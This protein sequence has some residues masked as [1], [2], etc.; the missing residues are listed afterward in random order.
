MTPDCDLCKEILHTLK[1]CYPNGIVLSQLSDVTID[2]RKLV[3][4]LKYLQDCKLIKITTLQYFHDN[5]QTS[6]EREEYVQITP[7]GIDVLLELFSYI[8]E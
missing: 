7:H 8:E 3:N 6:P 5:P 4:N 1:K 2:K